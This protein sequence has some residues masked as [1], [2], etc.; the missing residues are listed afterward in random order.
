MNRLREMEVFIHT[1]E[2][3]SLSKAAELMNIPISTAS[4]WLAAIEKRLGV[5]LIDRNTRNLA[6]TEL[7][8]SFYHQCKIAVAAVDEAE[9]S[10]HAAQSETAGV[11]RIT[12]S[13]SFCL[14]HVVPV[15]PTFNAQH[16][17]VEFQILV[18]NRY[19]DLIDNGIDVAF[20]VRSY[21]AD[22]NVVVRPL[23]RARLIVAAAPSYLK[24]YGEPESVQEL[25]HHKLLVYSYNQARHGLEFT[26][27]RETLRVEIKHHLEATDGRILTAAALLGQGIVVQPNYVLYEDIAAGRLVSLLRD[28]HLPEIPISIAY[29]RRKFLPRKTTT[30][31]DFIVQHFQDMDFERQWDAVA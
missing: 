13:A 24:R 8:A 14:K 20:R 12:G 6:L 9:A 7:G 27:G 10:L 5:R 25:A 23:A 26:R 30:F 17:N 11:L 16:P 4:R 31:I 18:A 15:L 21:N 28:W 2:Q 1:A 29:Q 19:Y 3:G 22:A